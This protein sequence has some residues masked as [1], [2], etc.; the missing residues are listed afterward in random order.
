VTRPAAES[1]LTPDEIDRAF[2]ERRLFSRSAYRLELLDWYTTPATEARLARFL[3]GEVV[4]PAERERWLSMLRAVIADG[5]TISRVHVVA[6][7]LTDY[8]KYE[9]ACYQT[10]T[11]AGEDIR[12]LPA[13]LA[14]GLA[15]PDFDYWLFDDTRVAVMLY[16]D[17]GAWQGAEVVTDPQFVADCRGWRDAAM[18]RAIPLN[19]YLEGRRS[20]P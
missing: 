9:L 13:D 18:S 3:A 1:T 20:P 11:D 5:Q 8:L 7:P 17:R 10:S 2:A 6:E 19:P 14:A 16:G 15:L 4:T 12:I